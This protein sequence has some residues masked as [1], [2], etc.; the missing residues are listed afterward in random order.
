MYGIIPEYYHHSSISFEFIYILML[1][2]YPSLPTP[3]QNL[4][5]VLGND[6]RFVKRLV[7]IVAVWSAKESVAKLDSLSKNLEFR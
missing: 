5:V 7:Y 3:D 6:S 2:E 4:G 1:M